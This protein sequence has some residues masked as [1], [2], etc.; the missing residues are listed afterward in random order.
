MEFNPPP[1]PPRKLI[2]QRLF[3]KV[4]LLTHPSQSQRKK[5]K[6]KSWNNEFC[7]ETTKSRIIWCWCWK[8]AKH[9]VLYVQ[10]NCHFSCKYSV[11]ERKF[12]CV[13]SEGWGNNI[14]DV[15]CFMDSYSVWGVDKSN[16]ITKRNARCL[17]LKDLM[18][19]QSNFDESRQSCLA[20]WP[21]I[22][23]NTKQLGTHCS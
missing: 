16:E 2:R 21:C 8:Q 22:F 15:L 13:I 4:Y 17:L 19:T 12:T 1:P 14:L 20:G 23:W 18:T 9:N 10:G 3:F 5:N 7:W 11:V 6:Y